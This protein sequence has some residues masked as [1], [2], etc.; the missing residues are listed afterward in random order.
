MLTLVT[1]L[2]QTQPVPDAGSSGLLL[3]VG[4]LFM[5]LVA[6]FAKNRKG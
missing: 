1:V 4:V 3:A 6:R 5:G 2:A